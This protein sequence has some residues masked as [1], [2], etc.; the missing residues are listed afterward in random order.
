MGYMTDPSPT[1]ESLPNL[2]AGQVTV[3][4]PTIGGCGSH[5]KV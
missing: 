1:C 2:L 4:V 3:N 5:L